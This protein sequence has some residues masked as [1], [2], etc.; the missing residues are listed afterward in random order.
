MNYLPK[1]TNPFLAAK[2]VSM[3]ELIL[4]IK[5]KRGLSI[6]AYQFH[7]LLQYEADFSEFLDSRGKTATP[8]TVTVPRGDKHFMLKS[9]STKFYSQNVKKNNPKRNANLHQ[10]EVK[11]LMSSKYKRQAKERDLLAYSTPTMNRFNFFGNRPTLSSVSRVKTA[12]LQ[13]PGHLQRNNFFPSTSKSQKLLNFES[14]YTKSL[15]GSIKKAKVKNSAELSMDSNRKKGF[16]PRQQVS[17]F[18]LYNKSKKKVDFIES[19]LRKKMQ[20]EKKRGNELLINNINIY[21]ASYKKHLKRDQY[22]Q[23]SEQRSNFKQRKVHVSGSPM[24]APNILDQKQGRPE[25]PKVFNA[26]SKFKQ[27]HEKKS[28]KRAWNRRK[29]SQNNYGND[30][31]SKTN[32][33]IEAEFEMNQSRDQDENSTGW[34]KFTESFFSMFKK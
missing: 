9:N 31:Y 16:R 5:L 3:K 12:Q 2:P 18:H 20:M 25:Q 22:R 7:K 15:N 33:E 27:N 34:K 24:V 11:K 23:V 13:T 10:S 28:I 26:P 6:T 29:K 19:N 4:Y 21:K 30:F 17:G 1:R 8:A 32:D 14:N